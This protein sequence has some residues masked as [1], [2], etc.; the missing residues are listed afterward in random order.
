MTCEDFIKL[1]QEWLEDV[2]EGKLTSS[3]FVTIISNLLEVYERNRG[4]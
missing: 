2:N 1:I 3:S 4:L